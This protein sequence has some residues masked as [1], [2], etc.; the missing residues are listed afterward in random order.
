M[1]RVAVEPGALVPGA[2]VSLDGDES[3]HLQ[4]RRGT[5]AM[6]AAAIDGAGAAATGTLVR[7]ETGWQF[8]VEDVTHVPRPGALWLAV[9]A[10]DRDRFLWVAEKLAELGVT[11]L[12]PIETARTVTVATRLRDGAVDKARRRAREGCKQSGNPWYPEVEPLRPLEALVADRDAVTW[13]LAEADAPPPGPALA[14]APIGWLIGP[15]G[16][17]DAS[18][19]RFC[20]E[21][22]G[23]TPRSLGP[24]VL[25]FETAAIAAAAVTVTI[26]LG[27]GEGER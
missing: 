25:R 11:R 21:A 8:R 13:C 27:G 16:G 2:L 1:I 3:H 15:E 23:A 5:D 10:G 6:P 9:A 26:R 12:L 20:V 24:H 14:R 4:V 7:A 19:R 22:L 17:F 18:E